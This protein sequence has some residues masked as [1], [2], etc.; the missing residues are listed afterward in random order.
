MIDDDFNQIK[1]RKTEPQL[2]ESSSIK[3]CL[4]EDPKN[5]TDSSI[6]VHLIGSDTVALVIFGVSILALLFFFLL[7]LCPLLCRSADRQ[8]SFAFGALSPNFYVSCSHAMI[9]VKFKDIWNLY[10]MPNY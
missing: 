4:M 8:R 10:F 2:F 6:D 5:D 7:E 9:P 3:Q 1:I